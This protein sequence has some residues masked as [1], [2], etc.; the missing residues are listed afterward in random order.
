[1]TNDA[2]SQLTNL[3][4]AEV[5]PIVQQILGVEATPRGPLSVQ[6]IGRSFGRGTVGIY[7]V[8]GH[9][10]TAGGEQTWSAVVKVID[11]GESANADAELDPQREVA[12]YQS[13]VFAA[14]HGRVRSAKCYAIEVCNGRQFVWQEDLSEA[15]QAPWGAK[16]FIET[17][18]HLGQFNGH[19]PASALPSWAWLN[20]GGLRKK[21]KKPHHATVFD[22]L[23][24]LQSH[25]LVRR[26]VSPDVVRRLVHL[27][28]ASDEVFAAV[29][30]TPKGVCHLDCHPRNLFPMADPANGAFTIAIDWASV[31]IDCLGADIGPLLASPL[32]WLDLSPDEAEALVAPIF[33]AYLRGLVDAGW[34]GDEDRVRLTYFTCLGSEVNRI[35]AMIAGVV[36]E[37]GL[38]ALI[39]SAAEQPIDEIFERW[40]EA[41][42]FFLA[43][44]EEALQ[45]ARRF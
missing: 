9:A 36:D 34:S 40:G 43:Y 31:G 22:R 18:R 10:T 41:Q 6:Q 25:D 42:H 35:A 30:A 45:L 32:K 12:V 11:M 14:L 16:H 23:A 20:Q 26:A 28:E 8:G 15:P 2:V 38:R 37:P 17:A 3:P 7:R 39:E 21:Y 1:M 13:G 27:W 24:A 19:W 33:A 44:S 29:E 4:F 5:L